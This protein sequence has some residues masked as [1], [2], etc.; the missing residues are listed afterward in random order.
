MKYKNALVHALL[1]GFI[2]ALVILV[3]DWLVVKAWIVFFAWANYFLH[4]CNMKKSLKML[5]AFFVGIFIALVG[6]YAIEYINTIAPINSELY[7]SVFIVFWIASILIFLE[8]IEG[9]GE[10]VPAT[11]LGTVLFYASG[12]T[13]TSILPE[14]LVPLLLG[15]FAGFITILSRKKLTLYLNK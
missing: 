8:I 12:I 9:W 6:T 4:D 7:V 15:I 1:V 11:F 3:S 14:L 2:A 5:L 13:F 10:F